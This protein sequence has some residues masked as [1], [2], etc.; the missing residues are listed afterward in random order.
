MK[1]QICFILLSLSLIHCLKGPEDANK[2]IFVRDE[3]KV[4]G[5]KEGKDYTITG[6][7]VA[8]QKAGEYVA[9][10]ECEEG[11]IVITADSVTLY[12]QNLVL[13]SKKNAPIIVT[14]NTKDVKIINLEN[15]ELNDLEDKKKTTGECAVIKVGS[16]STVSIENQDILTLNGECKSIIR[17]G[18]QASIVFKKG[19][20]EYIINAK[21]TAIES[22]GLLQFN[23]GKFTITSENGDAIR[24]QPDDDDEESLGKILIKDGAFNIHSFNDAITARNNIEILKGKFNITTENGYDSETY[25]E[26]NESAKGFKLTGNETGCGILIH[27][28]DFIVNAADDAFRS[29]RDITILSG[30]FTINTKDDAI[31]AKYDLVLGE[32][33]APL[34]DLKINIENSYEALEGMTV[35]IYSGKI[36]VR[37]FDDGINASGPEKIEEPFGPGRRNRSRRNSSWTF[38][39]GDWQFPGGNNWT[40]PGGDGQFPGGD[41]TF[42]GG[43]NWT[44]PGGDGQFPGGDWTFPGGDGQ[45]PG[46]DWQF[47]GGN[48]WTF[49][50]G[51]GQFPGGNGQFPG[52][53]GGN[54]G[55]FDWRSMFMP[56][57]SYLVSIQGGELYLYTDSDGIDSNGHIYLHG[58]KIYIFSE[59][60]GP[61]EPIDH[62]GNFTLFDTEV[63]G[64]G[65]KGLEAVHR[66]IHKGN[67]KYAFYQ[68]QS[69]TVISKGQ[70]LEILNEKDKLVK[71]G[72]IT[73]DVN[74]IF[75]TSKDLNEKYTFNLIDK[76]DKKTTLEMTFGDPAEGEDDLDRIFNEKHEDKD[77]KDKKKDKEEDE[78]ED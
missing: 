70:K 23:G 41:W 67:Q 68:A 51:N 64:V 36:K 16:N 73:K 28:G 12:L 43:N 13:S 15:T 11:N 61:N 63:L 76:K 9:L 66:G 34:D 54:G 69:Q 18:K 37:A 39:G 14:K 56:N 3:L 58:G 53:N 21:K 71:E 32:K 31:C 49:P 1:L 47:P 7:T 35:T 52:G 50:G 26:E 42:P 25:D 55:G 72:E 62:N 44:F 57:D 2:I 19:E 5:G 75:Y 78:D 6:Q 38:P 65:T 60:T 24:S 77:K 27:S 22:D 59:G 10:G 4:M 40:F 74:Y 20:G 30:R 48:N 17:G 46:G 45:F 29:N 8:I 33:D